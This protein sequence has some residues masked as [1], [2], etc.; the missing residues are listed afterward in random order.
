MADHTVNTLGA[1]MKA[2]TDVVAGAVAEDDPLAKEQ[3]ALVVA[4]LDFVRQRLDLRHA[5]ARFE[6]RNAVDLSVVVS[7]ITDPGDE[8]GV[9]G[10]SVERGERSLADPGALDKEL[11]DR[12]C[13][14]EAALRETIRAMAHGDPDVRRR[15]ERAVLDA[16]EPRVKMERAWYLPLGFDQR[17]QELPP[18]VELLG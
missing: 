13:A 10:Q 11:D 3:L 14:V 4:Y 5:R 15:V 1:A 17:P 16:S 2:L 6:L 12:R 8:T 18:L 9:L 7:A